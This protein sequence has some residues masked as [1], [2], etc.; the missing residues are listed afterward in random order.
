MNNTYEFVVIGGGTGGIMSASQII[1]KK[2]SN[3]VA[4]IDPSDTHFYQPA[5]TLVGAGTY[6]YEATKK[7]MKD[8]IPKGVTWVKDFVATINPQNNE[9]V[10]SSGEIITYKFLIVSPGVTNDFDKV[11]GLKDALEDENSGVSSVYTDPKKTW[12]DIQQFKGGVALFTQ[13]NTPI[14]CGGAP[15]K[16]MYLA[17]SAFNKRGVREKS[18]VIFASPG[19]V[20]FGIPQIKET[21]MK[22][23][24]RKGIHLRFGHQLESIDY[25]NKIAWY[26]LGDNQ[27]EHGT[28]NAKII[29][30]NGRIGIPYDL[31]HTAPP[32]T[33]PQFLKDAGLCNDEGWL[34]VD[35]FT[36]QHKGFKNIF[37]IG[38]A[39][40]LPTAKT[41]AAIRKQVPVMLQNILAIKTGKNELPS[42]YDGYS[43]CPLV[44]DYG[45]MVLAEFDYDGNFTPDPKLKWMFVFD[46]SKE[47][48]I[49]WLL[50]KF[51]L[52]YIYWNKM[53]KGKEV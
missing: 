14:K 38:D 17:E 47:S 46:S 19:G 36:L 9:V 18:D 39:A 20:I 21:L 52:P 50:K 15:Q 5:W 26:K 43:S 53:M 44:T 1:V 16:I 27:G 3:D 29:K 41:G 28:L 6:N 35:K 32:A 37:G 11:P 31:L 2:I 34:N 23:V 7:P 48:W 25:K 13:P 24:N 33:A 42:K 49:L 40:A 10:T 8:L 51:G 45:K 22:V 4:V 12:R 30:E